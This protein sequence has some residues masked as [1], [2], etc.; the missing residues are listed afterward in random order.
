MATLSPA[1]VVEHLARRLH[2]QE[3]L[4]SRVAVWLDENLRPTGVGLALV[5]RP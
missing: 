3:R 4:T 1:G 2:P 5:G